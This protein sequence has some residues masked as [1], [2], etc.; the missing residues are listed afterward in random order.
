MWALDFVRIGLPL[1][2]LGYGSWSDL[3]TREVSNRLWLVGFP[4][5]G[6]LT[7]LSVALGEIGTFI[8]VALASMG[9]T[10]AL[11]LALFYLGLV[12]GADAKAFMY[13]A[14]SV[15]LHPRMPQGQSPWDLTLILFPLSVFNNA[16]ILSLSIIL[17]VLTRNLIWVARGRPVLGGV[18]VRNPFGKVVLF[19]TSYRTSLQS[20]R[21][22]IYLYP[23][24][25]PVLLEGKASRKPRYFTDAEEDKAD[26]IPA[27]E[28]HAEAGLYGDGILATPTIPMILFITVGYVA[29]FFMDFALVVAMALVGGLVP[30]TT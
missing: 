8:F 15:P 18:D 9:I 16:V 13:I 5:G 12:G 17:L 29:A 3:R 28:K 14:L 1:V 2:L 10:I 22:K 25:I 7:A 23:A 20:L 6:A 30:T 27:I 26:L 11:A 19:A 24:E 4:V 21:E